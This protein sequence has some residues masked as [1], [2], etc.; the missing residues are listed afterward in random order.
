M[1]YHRMKIYRKSIPLMPPAHAHMLR[2]HSEQILG[3]EARSRVPQEFIPQH[4]KHAN[5]PSLFLPL[6][7]AVQQLEAPAGGWLAGSSSG[8]GGGSSSSSESAVEAQRAFLTAAWPR[9]QAWY[10]WFNTTQAGQL[11]GSYRWHGRDAATT[12]EL[13][14]KTLM[15]GLDDYPRASHPTEDERHLDLHCWMAL[16]SSAMAR[17]GA[18]AGAPEQLVGTYRAAAEQLAGLGALKAL[19]W[20]Q[21]SGQF[22]DWGL[23][24]EGVSLELDEVTRE[25]GSQEVGAQG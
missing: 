5:P 2:M 16:A 6:M 17:I 1:P 14:P 12:R 9:L 23:H 3:A 7:A 24:S 15:S 19:H 10:A 11:P 4:P 18:V 20:E 8:S 21:A 25:D 22:L 13:N